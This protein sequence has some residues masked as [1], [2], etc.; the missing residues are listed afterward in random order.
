VELGCL[1]FV[2][3]RFGFWSSGGVVGVVGMGVFVVGT[4]SGGKRFVLFSSFG[5]LVCC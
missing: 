1:V 2:G 3:S 5:V 4:W